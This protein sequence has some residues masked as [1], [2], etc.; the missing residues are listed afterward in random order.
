V[1]A[2]SKS[3]NLILQHRHIPIPVPLASFQQD[4]T[5]IVKVSWLRSLYVVVKQSHATSRVKRL[6][7]TYRRTLILTYWTKYSD[8]T[9]KITQI[10]QY[11]VHYILI[12][13]AVENRNNI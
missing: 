13:F 9:V 8:Y 11:F 10:S 7:L 6:L 4:A 3:T 12:L 5:K 2:I 1:S